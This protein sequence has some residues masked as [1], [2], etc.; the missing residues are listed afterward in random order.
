METSSDHR[1]VVARIEVNWPKLYYKK[2]PTTRQ[3]K[4]QKD[5]KT[6]NKYKDQISKTLNTFNQ[7]NNQESE[8]PNS[9]W[10][11]QKE[12]IVESAETN[13]GYEKNVKHGQVADKQL[14][15]MST[16]QKNMHLKIKNSNDPDK[17]RQLRI[18]RKSILKNMSKRVKEIK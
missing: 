15:K 2:P 16:E 17:I 10:N 7:E 13:I 18:K 5:A 4:L 3:Q 8:D 1:I 11:K 12:M 6:Q 14:E 9:R